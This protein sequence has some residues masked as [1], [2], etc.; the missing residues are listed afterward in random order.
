[1]HYAKYLFIIPC[2]W[3]IASCSPDIFQA[4]PNNNHITLAKQD[5]I[6]TFSFIAEEQ[7]S[8]TVSQE[9]DYTWFARGGIATSQGGYTGKL[10]HGAYEVILRS[11]KLV[12]KGTYLKGRKDGQWYTWYPNGKLKCVIHYQKG[13]L[14]G[15]FSE[16]D[17][18]GFLVRAGKYKNG[19]LH[20]KV[21]SYHHEEEKT[22]IKYKKGKVVEE[23][24]MQNSWK[25]KE[26]FDKKA[27]K[28]HPVDTLSTDEATPIAEIPVNSANGDK[29]KRKHKEDNTGQDQHEE[30]Q[31][32]NISEQSG[33]DVRKIR[34]RRKVSTA[35]EDNP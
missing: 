26:W 24:T 34:R 18:K 25:I 28:D 4:M 27:N 8:V 23:D 35:H 17:N 15:R 20:G 32:K 2:I 29:R 19:L 16:F 22:A 33:D 3:A 9:T 1:M 7:P 13:T 21:V 30:V 14:S 31:P 12:E 11:N 5:T 6:Y 10:L